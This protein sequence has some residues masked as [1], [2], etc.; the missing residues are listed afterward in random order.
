MSARALRQ[1][2]T[3]CV[4]SVFLARFA[5]ASPG[6]ALGFGSRALSL[7]GATSADSPDGSAVFY[8]PSGLVLAPRSE[9][10]LSY[11]ATDFALD[12]D[13]R[14]AN[15]PALHTLSGSLLGRGTVLG[16]P[17]AFGLALALTNGH[18]SRVQT[19]TAAEPRWVLDD[20]L[21]E[22]IDLGADIALRPVP[23][24]ELGGGVGFLAATQGGF[25]VRGSALL[26]DGQGSEYDSQLQHSV[27]A[28]LV[29]VRYPTLGVTATPLMNWAFSL[30]YRGEA[31]LDQQITGTLAGT[32]DAGILEFPVRYRFESQSVIAFQPR[33]AV[34]G[35]SFH[36]LR[37]RVN[38]DLSWQEWSR[39]PSPVGR[40]ATQVSASLPPGLGLE[41]PPNT[42]LAAA[43][44]PHFKNRVSPR[45]G[46]EQALAWT[47]HSTFLLRAGYAFDASPLP[48][49][50]YQTHFVDADR[51]V[52]SI[53]CGL[54]LETPSARLPEGIRLDAHALW[55]HYAERRL[56]SDG[57][58]APSSFSAAGHIWGGGATLSLAFK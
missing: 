55:V 8:N 2:W 58:A 16:M 27:D 52:L 34:L 4:A 47:A 11:S 6:H 3:F 49:Q 37:T 29:S 24:L 23:W 31:E 9:L 32:I 54:A 57:G 48:A 15:V 28:N 26:A 12:T 46:V 40:S 17:A 45:L 36:L 35:A 10:T 50:Q 56:D 44:D 39:Y 14:S 53:G 42:T 18:L 38:A 21:P 41:L 7:G 43:S 33:E 30:A 51:H 5:H 22:L 13:G 25:D 1:A 19:V 20:G